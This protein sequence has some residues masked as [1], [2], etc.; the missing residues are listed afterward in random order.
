MRP[1]P[2]LVKHSSIF[3][4]TDINIPDDLEL[5]VDKQRIQQLLINLSS[6]CPA[7]QP[8]RVFI[9]RI[10]AFLCEGCFDDP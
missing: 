10:S 2:S 6:K 8:D 9:L 3:G 1:A 5:E 7:C 4:K